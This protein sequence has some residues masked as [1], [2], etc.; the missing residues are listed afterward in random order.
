[1]KSLLVAAIC[2]AA[3]PLAKPQADDRILEALSQ[4]Q[5]GSAL[6][7]IDDRLKAAPSDA[8]L[9]MLRGAALHGLR[10][11]KES[12]AS[13]RKAVQLQPDLMPALQAVAQLEYAAKD[14]N[15]GKTLARILTLDPKSQVAH[16]MAGVLA[17]EAHDCAG[18]IHHF[19]SAMQQV[20]R[21]KVSLQ[22]YGY[23]LLQL[24]HP[25]DAATVFQRLLAADSG[26]S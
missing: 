12:L 20:E 24:N 13:Y 6:H 15:A 3:S 2:L 17:F 5:F 25:A 7:A 18:V 10:Q 8:R 4:K 22:Q 23:C 11:P 1:M 26:D 19:G 14:R 9:W 21:E 16:A